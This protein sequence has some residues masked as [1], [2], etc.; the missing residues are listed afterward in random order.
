VATA[1]VT[2]YA[3][4]GQVLMSLL[5]E[6]RETGLYGASF[7][8]FVVLGTVPGLLVGSVFPVLA[9][10]ARDDRT[11]LAYALQR[12]LEACLLLGAGTALVTAVGAP[13]MLDVVAGP[14]YDDAEPVLRLHA[15]A[16]LGSFLVAVG[17]FGL[18]SLRAH[19]ELLVANAIAL[20]TAGGLIAALAPSAGAEGT[21][22][23][24]VVGELLL[25]SLYFVAL[26]RAG[27]PL[28][29]GLAPKAALAAAAGALPA[30]LGAPP[31]PAAVAAGAVYV[32]ALL[33][34]GAVPEEILELVPGRQP[35]RR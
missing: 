31:L 4:L 26:R 17:G 13:A 8:I 25:F 28:G 27:L 3:Y 29:L 34:L 23:A 30:L 5:A 16:M 33:V 6:P 9:R 32:A 22:S 1:V 20:A 18:L 2:L 11:R 35:R 12:T 24:N 21:A 7:R 10:A 19:R 14:G 15:A